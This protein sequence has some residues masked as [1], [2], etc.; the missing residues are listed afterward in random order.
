[1]SIKDFGISSVG[2]RITGISHPLYEAS[3]DGNHKV[4]E[5]SFDKNF[6]PLTNELDREHLTTH[7]VKKVGND[8]VHTE[9]GE[10]KSEFE[11]GKRVKESGKWVYKRDKTTNIIRPVDPETGSSRLL[12]FTISDI[13]RPIHVDYGSPLIPSYKVTGF[14]STLNNRTG[15]FETEKEFH[16]ISQPN[17]NE[18]HH[19]VHTI[20]EPATSNVYKLGNN[21]TRITVNGLPSS[22]HPPEP[23]N[24][25]I[26]VN[27]QTLKRVG[28]AA[29]KDETRPHLMNVDVSDK[30]AVATDG[31]RIHIWHH[32]GALKD[33]G[34]YHPK[35]LMRTKRV[36]YTDPVGSFL[37]WN[38]KTKYT[39]AV[40]SSEL[41]EIGKTK[42]R[43]V[44]NAI[45]NDKYIKEAMIFVGKNHEVYTGEKP[46]IDP[47]RITSTDKQ[48]EAYVMPIRS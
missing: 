31:H 10:K 16:K 2:D 36:S 27:A 1:M 8:I 40:I 41:S 23:P 32:G 30:F 22:K 17:E 14:D 3:S 4:K 38:K 45:A 37:K 9:Y 6:A 26:H 18:I 39:P 7:E 15:E 19:E 35:T 20:G 46:D 25:N 44:G 29:S 21:P 28:Y 48:R 12:H 24:E 47:I 43:T 11:S 13:K 42:A 33:Q 5:G 34:S